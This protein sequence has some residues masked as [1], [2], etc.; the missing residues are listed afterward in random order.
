MSR[1]ELNTEQFAIGQKPP[2]SG[3]P[4]DYDGDIVIAQQVID[5]D[6]AAELAFNEEPVTIRLQP[7]ADKNA[8]MA[9]PVTVNGKPAEVFHNGRWTEIGYLPVN[10]NLTVKRKVLEVI[11]RSKIDTVNTH[12]IGAET[13][14]PRNEVTRL[15]SHMH[16]CS[17][18]EDQNPRG[19]VWASELI[20]RNF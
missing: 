3:N 5:K 19:A 13:E 10:R 6:Y 1:Q 12:I 9:M 14:N 2:I 8:A 20:N 15:T 16:S 17:I 11:L 7:S 4:A 18:L